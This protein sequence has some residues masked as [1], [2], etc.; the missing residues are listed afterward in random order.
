[1]SW[2]CL[3]NTQ[4]TGYQTFVSISRVTPHQIYW[5]LHRHILSFLLSVILMTEIIK[6]YLSK[7]VVFF[8]MVILSVFSNIFALI[9]PIF[10]I[11]VFNRYISSGVNATL[12]TLSIGAIISVI[13]EFFFRRARH[14]FAE[15]LVIFLIGGQ[16]NQNM[17]I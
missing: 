8:E 15:Q 9:P 4:K 2:E 5:P 17:K 7:P 3:S 10:V 11:L 13:F 14:H 12:I 16:L 1:M 6:I